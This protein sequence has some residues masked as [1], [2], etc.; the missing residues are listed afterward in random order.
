VPPI[1]RRVTWS[2][3]QDIQRL[4]DGK[5]GGAETTFITLEKY[6]EYTVLSSLSRRFGNQELF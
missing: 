2:N 1:L 4:F 6:I 5:Q 3:S